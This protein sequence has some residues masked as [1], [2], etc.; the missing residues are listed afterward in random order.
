MLSR[1]ARAYLGH[2]KNEPVVAMSNCTAANRKKIQT[3]KCVE[4]KL[5]GDDTGQTQDL[6]IVVR[7]NVL[8]RF[9]QNVLEP[10]SIEQ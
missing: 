4:V 10:G 2:V 5:G 8:I 1:G 3:C 9:F 7:E 6:L